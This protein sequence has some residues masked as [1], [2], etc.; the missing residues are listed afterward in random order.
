MIQIWSRDTLKSRGIETVVVHRVVRPSHMRSTSRPTQYRAVPNATKH[1]ERQT[2]GLSSTAHDNLLR[3]LE[4]LNSTPS[5]L[6]PSAAAKHVERQK[7]VS[8]SN[9]NLVR[10]TLI[11]KPC[12]S[13]PAPW[14]LDL[15][16]LN[17]QADTRG[18]ASN[19][20]QKSRA[21]TPTP[22]TTPSPLNLQVHTLDLAPT[23]IRIESFQ[24]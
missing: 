3:K 7:K 22:S 14:T 6:I 19:S 8:S 5:T 15:K 13:N 11:S 10:D 20:R 21:T 23:R 24:L 1:F 18:E 9:S 16:P 4:S 12:T 17:P 2:Q